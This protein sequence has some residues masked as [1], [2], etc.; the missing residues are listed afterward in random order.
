[1]AFNFVGFGVKVTAPTTMTD[2]EAENLIENVEE[3]LEAGMEDTKTRI[4]EIDSR[5]DLEWRI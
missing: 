5:L 2:E 3:A 1:M 4:K